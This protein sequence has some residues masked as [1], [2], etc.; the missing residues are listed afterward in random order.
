[1][2]IIA[3]GS[4]TIIDLSDGKSLSAYLGSNQP[5]VQINDVNKGTFSPDWTTEAG[6]LEI[7]PVVY[8]NQT[9]INLSD[10]ALKIEWK[11]K[12][13][14]G[15]ESVLE[16]D[17]TVAGNVLTVKANKLTG[18]D[19]NV[20]TY[21]AYVTYK[22]PETNLPINAVAQIDFALV[23]TGEHAKTAWI[24]GEQVFKY[25]A[26]GNATPAQITLTANL[27]N[28]TMSQWQY[29]NKDGAWVAYPNSDN[30]SVRGTSLIVKPTHDVFNG[31]SATIRIVTSDPNVGDST[32][33]YKVS[34][35][36]D[37]QPG[38]AGSSA[39][40]VFLTNENMT[41][42]GNASGQVAATTKTCNVVAYT[43]T[44]KVQPDVGEIT[45][46][47]S[48]KEMTIAKGSPMGNEIPITITVAAGSTL[49]GAGQ[50]QGEL[51]VPITSPVST[52]LKIQ[53][54][55]VNTGATGQDGKSAVIFAL[56][57]PDGEVFQNHQGELTIATQA[58]IGSQQI[59]SGATYAWSVYSGGKYVTVSGQTGSTL[60]VKGTDVT[61]I[62][63]YK[64]TMTY[65][66]QTYT[67]VITLTD[68]TD[69]YQATIESTG[70]DI[71]KNTQGEST[72]TCRLFQNGT[73]VDTDG[74][75]HT[76]K[77]YRMDK[78]G[79]AMDS[80]AVFKTGKSIDVNGDDV[81]VKTTFVCEVE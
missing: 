68:K 23:T 29:K 34:D 65:G 64:C 33:L 57:A 24:S 60:T 52:T 59:T 37:G 44:T 1:M 71:F 13:G 14:S 12:T 22:D 38:A 41:F 77:W 26:N 69:N 36:T 31:T 61:G 51:L 8:A 15:S 66:G 11:R 9:P 53:W 16:S 55:K 79:N 32:S 43:G 30:A 17:E 39:S 3:T 2:A 27:Q 46:A 4:K 6:K 35:G 48:G 19:G 50:Q 75:G 20:L 42:A 70:G 21:I 47:P 10:S 25:D 62:A 49:G 63:T 67:D 72:L 54:S 40:V 73:E 45:G 76:Y 81:D 18:A 58:Y 7:E 74:A 56:Y 28:V 80:G 5:R 78:N